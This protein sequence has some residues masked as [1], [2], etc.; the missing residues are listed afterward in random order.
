MS[1]SSTPFLTCTL[2][3]VPFSAH[4][5]VWRS[6]HPK[7]ATLCTCTHCTAADRCSRYLTSF[8]YA[9]VSN[10]P[11]D[12]DTGARQRWPGERW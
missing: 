8:T 7:C 3:R 6:A 2:W 4:S 10:D 9:I 11:S 1:R 5:G 12:Q